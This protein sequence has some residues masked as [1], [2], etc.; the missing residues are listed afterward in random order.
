M[1]RETKHVTVGKVA[2]FPAGKCTIVEIDGREFGIVQLKNGE[3]RAVR[4]LCPHKGAPVC[5]GFISGTMVP[6]A[7][8][9]LIY[10][11]DGEILVCPWHGYEFDLDTGK[12]IYQETSDKLLMYPVEVRNGEVVV[13]V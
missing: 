12:V 13:T 6:G 8:G 5:K 4:N 1:S 7:V 2:D 10:D 11:R 3:Y 9:E